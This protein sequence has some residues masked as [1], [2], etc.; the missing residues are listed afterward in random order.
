MRSI[1]FAIFA[2]SAVAATTCTGDPK[3]FSPGAGD[4]NGW[5]VD[6]NSRYQP[7]PGLRAEDVPKLKVK[8][9]VGL[10]GESRNAAQPVIVGG[11]V[12]VGSYASGAV[13][14]LDA[15]TGCVYWVY[16]AG[17]AVRTAISVVRSGNRWIAY[18]GD[19]HG[20]EHAIDALTGQLVWKVKVD[21]HPTARLSG[22]PTF[23]KGRLYV[24]VASGEELASMTP[25]YECCKFRGS[26]VSLD[27]NTGR[28]IWKTYTIPDPAKQYKTTPD[29]TTLYGPAGA[30]IWSA[31]SIDE[32][33][34]RIYAAT[35]NS[36]T[37]IDVPTSDSVVAFDLETGSLL[38]KNQMTPKDNWVPGC[39]KGPTCPEDPGADYDFGSSPVLRTV[40]G[41]K[42]ILVATQKSGVV[43]GLDPDQRG[44]V[45][46]ETRVGQ[47]GGLFG[48]IQWGAAFDGL[49]A[50]IA[51]GDTAPTGMPGLYALRIDTGAKL[52]GT[53]APDGA[54]NKPQPAAVSA[55]PGIAFSGSFGGRLRAYSTKTGEIVWDFDAVRDFETVN[56]VPGK[57]GSFDGGGPAISGG[58]VVTTNGYGFAG[59]LP[60][61]VVLGF[62]VD[63][64]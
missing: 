37:G 62:S 6:S 49:N 51:V 38:W 56:G 11:R 39:P 14:S 23:Y 15:S 61:N 2:V 35:G 24:P 58:M 32:K 41:G 9:A 26:L 52:W 20:T 36:Y 22:S 10:P 17:G 47:G 40:G 1:L 13:Y 45:L 8:W 16:E 5:G 46:W 3:P 55:M 53:P 63:G 28:V 7:Q 42:Q 57:G 44:K 54:R 19:F 29:G 59:G 18:F 4:W 48:G 50:Y 60:G 30:G 31:P 43:Y 34:K 27:A 12:F 25:K 21:E 64:K 33:R